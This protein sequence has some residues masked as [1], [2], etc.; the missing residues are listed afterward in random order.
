MLAVM[1]YTFCFNNDGDRK[2]FTD[3]FTIWD[4]AYPENPLPRRANK[5]ANNK[6]V[7]KTPSRKHV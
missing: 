6:C 5:T 7:I 2:K 4:V 3:F 1:L